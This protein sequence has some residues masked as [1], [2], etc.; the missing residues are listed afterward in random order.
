MKQMNYRT[1]LRVS[2]ILSLGIFFTLALISSEVYGRL[3]MSRDK[4]FSISDFSRDL[5]ED[6]DA[7]L[8]ISYYLSGR[9]ERRV[10]AIAEI[11]DLLYEYRRISSGNISI[12]FIDPDEDASADPTAYGI[13]PRELQVVE[14]NEQT[15]AMVYSG[16]AVSYLDGLEVI[17]IIVD[18]SSLEYELSTRIL[19]LSGGGYQS[20]GFVLGSSDEDFSR[21]GSLIQFLSQYYEIVPLLSGDIF[22]PDLDTALVM[23]VSA[24]TDGDLYQLEQMLLEGGGVLFA[25]DRIGVDLE[26]NLSPREI[27]GVPAFS[28]LEHHGISIE[29]AWVLDGSNQVIPVQQQQ[30][31]VLVNSFQ[32]YPQWP[33]I[34]ASGVDQQHPLTARFSGLDLFWASPLTIRPD[35]IDNGARVLIRSSSD[36]VLDRTFSTDPAAGQTRLLQSM[37]A[38]GSFP[39]LISYEG[40]LSAYYEDAPA[41]LGSL[42]FSDARQSAASSRLLVIG[43]SDFP[44]DLFQ[45]NNSTYNITFM[46]GV[47]EYLGGEE[48]LLDL[49]TRGQ[50]N[51][52][53]DALDNQMA[54]NSV[55]AFGE[56]VS[57]I[58][59]P[60]AVIAFAL[61]RYLL[62]RRASRKP[63]AVFG[64]KEPG[65]SQDE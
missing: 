18:S 61:T 1:Y 47:L 57:L 6:L 5:I 4:A 51:T 39:L 60:G 38:E 2:L 35:L 29:P 53:L 26:Q 31:Q 9:L 62:R 23:G 21:Y 52:R 15:F 10:P 7:P 24:L 28:F 33:R 63:G 64:K 22:P 25:A 14:N 42:A 55:L 46:Q 49:R 40:P 56:F 44:T 58:L 65:E 20:V 19:A 41:E 43:D 3:D 37:E 50:R 16:I 27:R 11:R 8:T 36:S 54:R 32:A 13:T 30:G 45:I 59:I 17:P 12:E 34:I 48:A